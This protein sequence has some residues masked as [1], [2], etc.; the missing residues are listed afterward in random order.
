M[1]DR[2]MK[3]NLKILLVDDDDINN[4][5]NKVIIEDM[6]IA[7]KIFTSSNGQEA[8]DLV[9]AKCGKGKQEECPDIIFL[10][11]NMPVMNGFEFLEEL[12]KIKLNKKSII[13]ILSSSDNLRDLQQAKKFG[14]ENYVNKPLSEE[15]I[16][17][18]LNPDL[19]L[20]N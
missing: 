14:I 11:I 18:V 16:V 15:K 19:G 1:K 9:K 20:S 2:I 12:K 6:K 4:F 5:L 10:D 7:D 13:V 17:K 3:N 8:L